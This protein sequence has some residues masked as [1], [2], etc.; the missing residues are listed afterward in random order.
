MCFPSFGQYS[1]IGPKPARKQQQK[2]TG[3]EQEAGG[4]YADVM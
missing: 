2:P 4:G 3:E 1:C